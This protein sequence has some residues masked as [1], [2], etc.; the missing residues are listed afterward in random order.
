MILRDQC[1]V[2]SLLH[3]TYVFRGKRFNVLFG[4]FNIFFF[5]VVK[6]TFSSTL[7]VLLLLLF[8]CVF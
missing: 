5:S 1:F 6:K 7:L 2:G 3:V 8:L 4:F